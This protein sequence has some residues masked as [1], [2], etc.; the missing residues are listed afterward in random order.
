[1]E[2]QI[3]RDARAILMLLASKPRDEFV[4][5]ADIASQTNLTPDRVN[6]AMAL[7]VDSG[8]A[9]WFRLWA[10]LRSTLLTPTSHREDGM[11]LSG[12]VRPQTIRRSRPRAESPL[13]RPPRF[14]RVRPDPR[15]GL[16]ITTG[17]SSRGKN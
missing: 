10:R 15:M 17:R 16:P 2:T 14:R 12:Y 5:A 11:R 1:M 9:E 6:D 3:D 13:P 7:L 4:P 8:Y